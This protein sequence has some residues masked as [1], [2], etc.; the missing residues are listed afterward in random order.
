MTTLPIII[1]LERRFAAFRFS[2]A[3]N[4]AKRSKIVLMIVLL[5]AACAEP[6]PPTFRE[7]EIFAPGIEI[8]I[9][10]QGHGR[11]LKRSPQAND[12][13]GQF[14]LTTKQYQA[15]VRRME[16]YRKSSD[17]ME[18]ADFDC[19]FM[20]APRCNEYRTDQAV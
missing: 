6:S 7:L 13:I 5:T 2:F 12:K 3:R 16:V 20:R 19:A 10:G 9:D 8:T 4:D 15:L 14:L 17:A 11:V 18:K 1:D